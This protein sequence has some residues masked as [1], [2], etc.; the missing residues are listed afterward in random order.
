M[1]HREDPPV[2]G[3]MLFGPTIM[4]RNRFRPGK[5]L[6]LLVLTLLLAAAFV[7]L[8]RAPDPHPEPG[9]ATQEKRSLVLNPPP[10]PDLDHKEGRAA[11]L[12]QLLRQQNR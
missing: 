3:A 2:P 10:D 5:I 6:A 11:L 12:L 9:N 7:L 8:K 1:T 4:N